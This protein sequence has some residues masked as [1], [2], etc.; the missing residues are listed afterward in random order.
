MPTTRSQSKKFEADQIQALGQSRMQDTHKPMIEWLVFDYSETATA[1]KVNWKDLLNEI[2]AV[3]G[4]R[5]INFACPMETPQK[6]W[7]IIRK[8]LIWA[9]SKEADKRLNQQS[10]CQVRGETIF[11]EQTRLPGRLRTFSTNKVNISTPVIESIIF[12]EI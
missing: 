1:K 7:I 9:T 4:C 11:T 3:Q 6:L 8:F 2:Q 5:Y 10:G 12:L